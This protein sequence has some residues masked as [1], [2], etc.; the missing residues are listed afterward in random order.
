[1]ITVRRSS[2]RL[3]TRVG[4]L[5]SRHTFSWAEHCDP[6]YMGYRS[7]RVL[8]EDRI[9]PGTGFGMQARRDTE[10]VTV[11]LAGT[12]RHQDTLGS[13]TLVGPGGVQCI[14]AGSGLLH[15]EV[16][17]SLQESLH[18][19][20]VWIA[21][22]RT[23]LRPAYRQGHFPSH[24]RA[25]RFALIV[26]N[27]GRDGSLSIHQDSLISAAALTQRGRSQYELAPG[28][29]A[30]IQVLSGTMTVNGTEMGQGDGM[31]LIDERV[32]SCTSERGGELLL[33]RPALSFQIGYIACSIPLRGR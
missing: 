11:V 3:H 9:A 22:A 21:P 10:I 20:Q 32:I 24:R 29:H 28:R 25:D 13:E 18:I 12:L 14:T 8:N 5:E 23:R 17:A 30:W 27:D 7:L 19:V 1:V 16:N 2:E 15:S 6:R 4:W 33:F 26:S 31:S